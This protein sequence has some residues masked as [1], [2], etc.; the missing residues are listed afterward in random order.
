VV[1][2]CEYRIYDNKCE[3]TINE[4]TVVDKAVAQGNDLDPQWPNVSL[5]SDQREGPQAEEYVVTFRA[6]DS[7]ETYTYHVDSADEFSRFDVGS[8]WML[9]VNTFGDVTDVEPAR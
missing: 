9:K 7:N 2:D 3:Y 1:Q 4:W 8:Y 6:D 5:R